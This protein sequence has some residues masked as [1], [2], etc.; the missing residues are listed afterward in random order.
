MEAQ[1][2]AL[3][4][5]LTGLPNRRF[6]S[7]KL[8]EVLSQCTP[9]RRAAV[10][11]LDLNHFKALNDVYGHAA[12]DKALIAFAERISKLAPARAVI[13][14]VGGDEFAVVQPA[15]A[16]LEDITAFTHRIIASMTDRIMIEDTWVALDAGIG[17][18]VAPDNGT[19]PDRVMRR[20]DL[21]LYRAKAE[22]GSRIR[23][24]ETDMDRFV[25]RRARLDRELRAALERG[26]IEVHYQPLLQLDTGK[27]IGFEALAR[28]TSP[29]YGPVGPAE[30]IAIAEECGLINELG[31][32][33]LRIACRDATRWPET[34]T[35]SFNISP[36]QQR[37]VSL[38]LRVLSILSETGLNPR[39]LELEITESA[40]V[41]D[42][43]L[44]QKI[45]DELRAAGV[46]IALDDFGTGYATMSQLMAL[47]FDKIKIDHNFISRLGMDPQ[48]EVI[49]RA[50]V[51]LARGLG[52]AATAEG[53]EQK[54]QLEALKTIG[55]TEGQG[56]LFGKAIPAGEIPAL[57]AEAESA[58]PQPLTAHG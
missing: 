13:A 1:R 23:F 38:G 28:W 7:E 35:L 31:D 10:L 44:A 21:A 19:E 12:G 25:E 20:A 11:M 4:D 22:G 41:K 9:D 29:S 47:R 40:L 18:A 37:N 8:Q 39:R 3:H 48:S 15:I 16:S 30:F 53:V 46:R 56:Y 17:I 33:L 54:S 49:V 26:E 27:I 55:C 36:L 50:T 51:G 14:R 32:K 2:L 43:G 42:A 24:F 6:F 45:V 52:L 57:L 34:M 5:P 58:G